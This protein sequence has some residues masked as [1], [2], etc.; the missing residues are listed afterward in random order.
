MQRREVEQLRRK[1]EDA[2]AALDEKVIIR[3]IQETFREYLGNI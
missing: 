3:V 1:A 2:Q